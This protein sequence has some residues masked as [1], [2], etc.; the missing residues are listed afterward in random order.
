MT[1]PVP[2]LL[3]VCSAPCSV[4][5]PPLIRPLQNLRYDYTRDLPQNLLNVQ[6]ARKARHPFNR[7]DGKI[8]SGHLS[9]LRQISVLPDA[10][11]Q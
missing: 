6:L 2:S 11:L 1:Y 10:T 8:D 4:S 9:R 5:V 3:H 7:H